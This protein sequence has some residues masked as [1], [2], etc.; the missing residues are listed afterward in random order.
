MVKLALTQFSDI[1]TSL[2]KDNEGLALTEYLLLLGL[3]TAGI[4]TAVLGFGESLNVLWTQWADFMSAFET[5]ASVP[6][7]EDLGVGG[8]ETGAPTPTE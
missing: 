8:G 6:T 4:I 1:V 3:I 7:G 5:A 2:K